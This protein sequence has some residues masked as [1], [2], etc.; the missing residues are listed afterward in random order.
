MTTEDK[1]KVLISTPVNQ[2]ERDP[3][4]D[5]ALGLVVSRGKRLA[6]LL[7]GGSGLNNS[8]RRKDILKAQDLTAI[9]N[10]KN[11]V[12]AFRPIENIMACA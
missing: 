1:N 10:P 8:N 7:G 5:D 12:S 3:S 4:A 11:L 6:S 9:G 2:R